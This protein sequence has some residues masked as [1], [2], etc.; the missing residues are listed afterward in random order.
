MATRTLLT[1]LA[2][3]L[4]TP[5]SAQ[6]FRGGE[7]YVPAYAGDD[8]FA[9]EFVR[10]TYIGAPLTRV[11]R[12]TQIVPAPWSYGTYGIPTVS[13]IASPPAA[14]P[15]LTVINATSPERRRRGA[16]GDSRAT[17]ARVIAVQVPRR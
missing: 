9:G 6:T 10:G 1:L 12:P 4:V 17:G 5:A 8:G 3:T 16:A 7:V 14:Q 2:L 11:P 15:T 13:G